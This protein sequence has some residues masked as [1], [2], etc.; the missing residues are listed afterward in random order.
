MKK[1]ILLVVFITTLYSDT[2]T[3]TYNID[4]WTYYTSEEITIRC[5]SQTC[6]EYD[7][8]KAKWITIPFKQLSPSL[9]Q[10]IKNNKG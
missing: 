8:S 6:Q 7:W 9:Q 5:Q 2:L 4:K 3:V 10:I 1:L